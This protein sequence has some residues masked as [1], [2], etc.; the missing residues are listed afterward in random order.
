MTTNEKRSLALKGRKKSPEHVEKVRLANIGQKRSPESRE[1]MR[2][3]RLGKATAEVTKAKLSEIMRLQWASGKRKC[4][5]TPEIWIKNA[6]RQRE[7][8]GPRHPAWIKDRSRLKSCLTSRSAAHLLW[9]RA[10]KRRFKTCV[11]AS[12]KNC[13]GRLEAHHIRSW[14]LHEKLRY[15][16]DN[17]ITLCHKHHPTK[18]TEAIALEPIFKQI[19]AS[20]KGPI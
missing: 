14:T 9:S 1:R 4:N 6:E 15:D 17:G 20:K 10:V 8:T 19:V 2:Q 5:F 18:T 7:C 16:V 12:L 11:L 3:S 13:S